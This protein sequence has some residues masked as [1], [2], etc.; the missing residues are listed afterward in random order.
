MDTLYG[1]IRTFKK[2]GFMVASQ[3]TARGQRNPCWARRFDV[4][5]R[6]RQYRGDFSGLV[7]VCGYVVLSEK[8]INGVRNT[9]FMLSAGRMTVIGVDQRSRSRII[10]WISSSYISSPHTLGLIEDIKSLDQPAEGGLRFGHQIH[11]RRVISS[12]R[13]NQSATPYQSTSH[14]PAGQS[15]VV[16]SLAIPTRLFAGLWQVHPPGKLAAQ[17]NLD[18][19]RWPSPEPVFR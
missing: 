5:C 19:Q 18:A 11:D 9:A 1:N 14:R 4:G 15:S 10:A 3:L 17:P 12:V 16:S 8:Y 6:Q 13:A 7:K 2:T